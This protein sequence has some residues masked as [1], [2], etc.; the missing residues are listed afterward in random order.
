[1]GSTSSGL[2]ALL[3]NMSTNALMCYNVVVYL[4][5]LMKSQ[6]KILASIVDKRGAPKKAWGPDNESEFISSKIQSTVTRRTYRCSAAA[7]GATLQCAVLCAWSTTKLDFPWWSYRKRLLSLVTDVP[8][9]HNRC[10][11]YYL[12]PE[13]LGQCKPWPALL[14]C[15]TA[16]ECGSEK[17]VFLEMVSIVLQLAKLSFEWL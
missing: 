2:G 17:Q 6:E 16:E 1:M 7:N 15:Q 12:F 8:V 13:S 4:K 9:L 11:V 10:W 5:V 14:T 3:I